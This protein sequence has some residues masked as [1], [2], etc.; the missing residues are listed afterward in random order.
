[1]EE[2]LSKLDSGPHSEKGDNGRL[3]I[4]GGSIEFAGPPAL[5]GLAALRTGSDVAKVLTSEVAIEVVAGFSPN[6][7][8]N[9]FTGDVL[10]PDS[11]GKVLTV[12]EWSDALVVGPGLETPNPEAIRQVVDGVDVPTVVDATAIGPALGADFEGMVLTPDGAEV[13]RIE[14]EHGSLDEFV[15]ATGAVV[16]SKG[17]EDVIFDGDDRYVN[18]EG[19]PAMTVAGTGD[20]LA[21][22][23]GSL[24]GQGLEPVDAARLGPWIVGR[25]GEL[26][27]DEYGSGMVATDV[28]DRVPAAFESGG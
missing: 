7:L 11:V 4:V 21:G 23:V 2:L 16:V 8:T 25:A 15:R 18:D 3:G 5:A 28:I 6:L 22:V 12:A 19:T 17:A 14:D 10:T 1:M 24:L 26:A 13:E 27:A 20:T 9:R